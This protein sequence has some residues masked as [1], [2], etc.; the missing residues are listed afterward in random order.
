MIICL[1][2]NIKS[3]LEVDN[4]TFDMKIPY[5]VI[6]SIYFGMIKHSQVLKVMFPVSLQY[7]KKE[8]RDGVHFCIK[9]EIIVFD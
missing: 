4:N 8:A 7:L 6:L 2:I 5:K 3:F 9:V 1:Q